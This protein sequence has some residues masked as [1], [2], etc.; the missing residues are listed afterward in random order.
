MADDVR[1]G[2]G[3]VLL[4]PDASKF[5]AMSERDLKKIKLMHQVT[6]TPVMSQTYRQ[7]AKTRLD[8]MKLRHNVTLH[9]ALNTG[10]RADA[11]AKIDASLRSL[12]HTVT[13]NLNVS[14]ALA[15]A[16]MLEWRKK[17]EANPIH[18]RV[19]TTNVGGGHT[20]AAPSRQAPLPSHLQGQFGGGGGN[21]ILPGSLHNAQ[22]Q[23]NSFN[24]SNFGPGNPK[25]QIHP[26]INPQSARN[27]N[28]DPQWRS[29][30]RRA[31]YQWN[32]AFRLRIQPNVAG[33][34]LRLPLGA[35]GLS[36]I[37]A[38]VS[39]L[40]GLTAGIVQMSQAVMVLPGMFAMAGASIGTFA[41]GISGLKDAWKAL[42]DVEKHSSE[43]ATQ[44][45]ADQRQ[46]TT[47]VED[48]SRARRDLAS[49]IQ[50]EQRRQRD[51]SLQLRG[52]KLSEAE[53]ILE[54]QDAEAEVRTGHFKNER[55]RDHALLRYEESKQN[56][57]EVRNRNS[58]LAADVAKNE[59]TGVSGS[60]AVV[61]ASQ[62]LATASERVS[63]ATQQ[64]AEG[65]NALQAASEKAQKALGKL[66]P[67]G[68]EF[69][70]TLFDMRPAFRQFAQEIQEPLA[71]GMG[72]AFANM[73]NSASIQNNLKTGMQGLAG[74]MNS[75]MKSV[76]DNISTPGTGGIITRLF[77]GST[78]AMQRISAQVINPLITGLGTLSAA[79]AEAMP[80]IITGMGTL[81]D[82][83]ANF[84]TKADKDGSL[85]MWINQGI[86]AMS[87]FG[88][89][90]VNVADSL[91]GISKAFGGQFLDTVEKITKQISEFLNSGKGQSD[92]KNFITE[93]KIA[94]DEWK[95][96]LKDLP[97]ILRE[98]F[99][100]GR[101]AVQTFLPILKG[102][103]WVLRECP[104]LIEAVVTAFVAWKTISP[105]MTGLSGLLNS[106]SN[107]VVNVGTRFGPAKS[108]AEKAAKGIDEA[109]TK[110]GRQGGGM[111]SLATKSEK[112]AIAFGQGGP[113]VGAIMFG[114]MMA[115][116]L[117]MEKEKDA[118]Q[119]TENLTRLTQELA[120]TMDQTT[121]LMTQQTRESIG[122]AFADF[123]PR[124]K[125]SLSG[126]V[127]DAAKKIG[128]GG[129][130][131]ADL[132]TAAM[133]AGEG[134]YKDIMGQL[135][136]K[137]RP[138]VRDFISNQG[139]IP[140][141]L[142]MTEDEIIDAYLGNKA[143]LE[144]V[145]AKKSLGK[146]IVDLGV[147]DN[148]IRR[149]GGDALSAALVGQ[150]LSEQRFGTSS[151]GG[152]FGQATAAARPPVGLQHAEAFGPRAQASA[153]QGAFKIVS[154]KPPTDAVIAGIIKDSNGSV[155]A[156]ENPEGTTPY[157]S[158][159]YTLSREQAQKYMTGLEHYDE[160]GMSD[161]E[162]LA[163]L[164]SPEYVI[165]PKGTR[166]YPRPFFDDLNE[167]RIDPAAVDNLPHYDK[168]GGNYGKN[169]PGI[170]KPKPD[171]IHGGGDGGPDLIHGGDV[172]GDIVPSITD[173]PAGLGS[174]GKN[175]PLGFLSQILGGGGGAGGGD[176]GPPD[177]GNIAARF[178]QILMSGVLGF[179][180]INPQYLQ[181]IG[182]VFDFGLSKI[183]DGGDGYSSADAKAAV[184]GSIVSYDADGSP[185]YYLPTGQTGT[186][187]PDAGDSS[188]KKDIQ[189]NT[190]GAG[191]D[192]PGKK[193]PGVGPKPGVAATPGAALTT[194][195]GTVK[196]LQVTA[197][198]SSKANF[199]GSSPPDISGASLAAR[200]IKPLYTWTG[201][202]V[203]PTPDSIK[204]LAEAFGLTVSTDP[205]GALHSAGYAWD[206]NDPESKG[207]NSPKLDAFAEFISQHLGSQTLQLI[208]ANP[209]TGQ[210]W[211]IAAGSKVGPGTG[212]P[213]YYS[214]DWGLHGDH[215]HWA[216]DLEPL[217][218]DKSQQHSSA[219]IA[220]MISQNPLG[221]AWT[222]G[223]L[224]PAW[225]N[226][227]NPPQIRAPIN[228][229]LGTTPT[230]QT[231]TPTQTPPSRAPNRLPIIGGAGSGAPLANMDAN[232]LFG[233]GGS[234]V[235]WSPTRGVIGQ[236]GGSVGGGAA[237]ATA[238]PPT[239]L[240][241]LKALAYQLYMQAGMPPGEWDAF[242][243]LVTH[244]SN[245][246]PGIKNP[247]S[248]A[249]GLGQFLDS[250]QAAYGITGSTD[251]TAQL[252]AMFSYLRNRQDYGGSPARA[253]K[254]W[255]DR[256]P[257][258]YDSGGVLPQGLTMALNS[259]GDE[260]LVINARQKAD[261][262]NALAHNASTV[263]PAALNRSGVGIPSEI[264]NAI[265][266]Q[267]RELNP[268]PPQPPSTGGDAGTLTPPP[269][270]GGAPTGPQ[271]TKTADAAGVAPSTAGD[272]S[273]PTVAAAPASGDHLLPAVRKGIESTASTVGGLAAAA[274]SMGMGGMGGGGAGMLIDGGIKQI[275]KIIAGVANVGSAALGGLITPG[276]TDN[277]YG[278]TQQGQKAQ[279]LIGNSGDYST[280]YHGDL[281]TQ[282]MD[283]FMRRQ[284][285]RDAQNMQAQLN[286]K[287]GYY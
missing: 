113:L 236:V 36:A 209:T 100:S 121:G 132:V 106:F 41:V 120:N 7:D 91:G 253:W 73:F 34:Q 269:G 151:A 152:K 216:T 194:T 199:G 190:P 108:E 197:N 201:K 26:S 89:I 17:Q 1:V 29:A 10:F 284:E 142:G 206:F 51:L 55:E 249:F 237:A 114:A 119:T 149:G 167:G 115:L 83:F 168:G 218:G 69:I 192:V 118:A 135:R 230:P 204:K 210:K 156:V 262:A 275:G 186:A 46:L 178:G 64:L 238:K 181:D 252:T 254:L 191:N 271:D 277:P 187:L 285:L 56:L 154:D 13:L 137:V 279:P 79:G 128:V 241:G 147:L 141:D 171:P 183:G 45:R 219:D 38:M 214:S 283:D 198:P 86:D 217:I 164:H 94:M 65:S 18:V 107:Q 127:F 157:K 78:D 88:R 153:G 268:T 24:K 229:P 66:A 266:N 32:D 259:T 287:P 43:T 33:M 227:G 96:I 273:Q 160:G 112:L 60:D 202:P 20:G 123:H 68:R 23:L 109:F 22:Q 150:A 99:E 196:N 221:L 72:P 148:Q 62:A 258:W 138:A 48:Q 172:G 274:A 8:K 200:G 74:G 184:Q 95:P 261:I 182:K 77:A 47:A 270:F 104:G 57:L 84:I 49:A 195:S 144:K 234:G 122:T 222:R 255:Q 175:G 102:F 203:N 71:K 179:F 4:I 111:Q 162:Q 143:A 117:W 246:Q 165:S 174:V 9:P 92:L 231:P 278:I 257:H 263:A 15:T 97:T 188:G 155:T 105:I 130:A 101:D 54:I 212:A 27:L 70:Q 207:G 170:P 6:L 211:G 177:L 265:P 103:T 158:W 232:S 125:E 224:Q 124:H 52:A 247:G 12:S 131:G 61:N 80:R 11:K 25:H 248:T 205:H 30:L 244:E 39:Q 98:A 76:M 116:D 163:V 82:R 235:L 280:H 225:K 256:S 85:Q 90:V 215:V 286:A 37:P 133:P 110:A 28:N 220:A 242:D 228:G 146:P 180:G 53:A 260:E 93:T 173:I 14:T 31:S 50:G 35:L 136:D 140:S 176:N 185:I 87:Q 282:D 5:R 2:S 193:W 58:D 276:T 145:S 126:N 21:L 243:Q 67:S 208:H 40:G 239:D 169:D 267:M 281:Y 16:Q 75:V 245:W 250:T 63:E 81:A 19:V 44:Q 251:P 139:I 272:A 166:K 159:T 3:S 161:R 223:K 59:Q 226:Y 240:K 264:I 42:G 189:G 213:N 134:K 233:G 129:E